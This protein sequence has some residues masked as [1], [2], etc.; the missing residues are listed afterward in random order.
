MEDQIG[1]DRPQKT[2]LEKLTEEIID[3]E[4]E[5]GVLRAQKKRSATAVALAANIVAL[6]AFCAW[7]AL[8]KADCNGKILLIPEVIGLL[9][10]ICLFIVFR[11][12]HT[13]D[14]R[15]KRNFYITFIQFAI[16]IVI[17][18]VRI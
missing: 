18:I 14:P 6:L 10:V 15:L 12:Y 5:E 17:S 3:M 8:L 7:A 11:R 2:E 9:G 4:Y 1:P 16:I 13:E